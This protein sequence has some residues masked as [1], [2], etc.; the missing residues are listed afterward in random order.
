MPLPEAWSPQLPPLRDFVV[1]PGFAGALV[2][3][4]AIIVFCAVLLRIPACRSSTRQT[5]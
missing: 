5:A 1:S 2:L 4:A 3:L